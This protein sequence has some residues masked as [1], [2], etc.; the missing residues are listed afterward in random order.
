MEI[1]P[2][3]A[4]TPLKDFVTDISWRKT[5]NYAAAVQDHNPVYFD[6]ER[7]GG[8]IAPPMFSVAVTWPILERLWE[9]IELEKFP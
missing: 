1:D 6:D 5:T 2:S 7:P 4:G 3:L 9:F 8:L